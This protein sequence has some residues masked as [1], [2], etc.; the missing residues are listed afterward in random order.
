MPK[1]PPIYITDVKNILPLI[2][3]LEEIAKQ[4]YEIKALAENQIKV[5]LQ[6]SESYRTIIKALA[7][8]H[9]EFHT[10]KLEERSYRVSVKKYELLQQP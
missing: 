7:K 10:Y 4:Q 9:T 5:L 1:P 8:K 3:L 6:T 2:Q